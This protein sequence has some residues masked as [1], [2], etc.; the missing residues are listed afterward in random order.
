[1][2]HTVSPARQALEALEESRSQV[3]RL[4]RKVAQLESRSTAATAHYG[5]ALGGG[6]GQGP[7]ELWAEL[8]DRRKELELREH[9]LDRQEKQLSRWIDQLPRP[10]WRMVLRYRYLDGM[11]FQD[12]A[13]A[14]TEATGREFSVFQI[15]R[16]HAKAIQTADAQ[17]P[18]K[19]D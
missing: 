18:L 19:E 11:E 1:M 5:P 9:R 7:S 2:E 14:M 10:R 12:I 16:L 3:A 8:A 6:S 13:D 4:R 17:W 15:Y